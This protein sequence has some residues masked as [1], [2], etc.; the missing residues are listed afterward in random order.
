M[1]KTQKIVEAAVSR[2]RYYGVA[3][4]TMQEIARDAGVSVG[5]LY[6]YFKN[7]DDLVVACTNDFVERHRREISEILA[8]EAPAEERL[9]AYVLG[10][11]RAAEEVRTGSRHAVELTR[12]VLRLKPD[13][14]QEEGMMIW[15]TVSEILEQGVAQRRFHMA[16]V[17]DDARVF[18]FSIAYFFPNALNEP[19]VPPTEADLLTVVDWFLEVWKGQRGKSATDRSRRRRAKA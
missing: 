7:K 1:S 11:F 8:A 5:T 16:S 2:F 17:E 14:A 9:R 15:E 12:V 3:K 6:L 4:T 13:R 10:R 18:L 19:P